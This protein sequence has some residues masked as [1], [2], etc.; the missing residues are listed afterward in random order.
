MASD[1]I[2]FGAVLEKEGGDRKVWLI[3]VPVVVLLIAGIVWGALTVSRAGTYQT[4][5]ERAKGQIAELQKSIDE[6][7]K[8]LVQARAD[9]AVMKSAGQATGMFFGV[10]K[11]ATESG[12]AIAD[13]GEKAVRVYLY[14]LVAPPEGQEYVLAARDAQGGK[15]PLGKV[16]PTENGNGFLL[17]KGMPEGT[18]AIE[19]LFRQAGAESLDGATPRVAARYPTSAEERGILMQPEPKPA[20]QARRGRR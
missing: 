17:A 6:R 7:D 14:G 12:I 8:L 5:V 16:I 9:E 2:H 15:K 11:D 19:L 10:A 4:E 18:A 13:P 1:R 20:A 3:V